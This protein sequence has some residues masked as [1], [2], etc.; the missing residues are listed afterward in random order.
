MREK[1]RR[2]NISM[3]KIGLTNEL[4]YLNRKKVQKSKGKFVLIQNISNRLID[5]LNN[6]RGDCIIGGD[7][8]QVLKVID[9]QKIKTLR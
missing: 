2:Y 3:V 4:Y 1:G 9:Y 6:R 8:E 7:K 5:F